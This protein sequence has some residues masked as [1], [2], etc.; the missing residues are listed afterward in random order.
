K[1]GSTTEQ[2]YAH[3][4]ALLDTALTLTGDS[5]RFTHLAH[6]G[7]ARALLGLGRFAEAATAVVDV[8]DDFRYTVGYTADN[9]YEERGQHF[10][11]LSTYLPNPYRHSDRMWTRSVGDREGINGLDFVSSG[12][13]RTQTT[14]TW[15]ENYGYRTIH[16]P[17]KYP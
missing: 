7:R 3:A 10:A 16:H 1:P 17:S 4:L 8:P 6:V 5:A 9:P 13:P 14:S 2:V 11:T 12:D 15:G